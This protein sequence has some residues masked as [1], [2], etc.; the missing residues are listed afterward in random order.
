MND[1]VQDGSLHEKVRLR[2]LIASLVFAIIGLVA[3]VISL[4]I[5]SG[6]VSSLL[7]ELTTLCLV[8][9]A[10]STIYELFQRQ[11]YLRAADRGVSRVLARLTDVERGVIERLKIANRAEQVGLSDAGLDV[12]GYDYGPLLESSS[13]VTIIVNDGRTWVSTNSA[14]LRKRLHDSSKKTRIILTHPESAMVSVLALK[15]GSN[16]SAIK[17]KLAETLLMLSQLKAPH[18]DLQVFGHFLFNPHS[19]F[20]GDSYIV[21]TPYFHGRG[22]RSVPHLRFDDKAGDCYFKQSREDIDTL[23]LDA[24]EIQLVEGQP[25]SA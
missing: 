25:V 21:I 6:F 1:D 2:T 4:R 24:R 5:E 19:V 12:T 18:S 15:E 17:N 13:S 8:G 3:L 23:L 10:L 22:R 14:R 20:L 11:D 16:A 7:R 9:G